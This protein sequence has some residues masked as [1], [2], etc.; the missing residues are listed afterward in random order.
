MSGDGCQ[1]GADNNNN[2]NQTKS[3]IAQR[4]TFH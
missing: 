1:A 3:L 2:T 4:N